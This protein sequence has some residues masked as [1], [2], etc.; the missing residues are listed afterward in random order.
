MHMQLIDVIL[1]NIWIQS[2]L[3]LA[4]IQMQWRC[5]HLIRYAYAIDWC[6]F[7]EHMD[8]KRRNQSIPSHH[9]GN[10]KR[11]ICLTIIRIFVTR[12]FLCQLS[13]YL[14]S[15][16]PD[17]WQCVSI[18]FLFII[19]RMMIIFWKHFASNIIKWYFFSSRIAWLYL[20]EVGAFFN[21]F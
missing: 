5:I 14:V 8:T 16:M 17:G 19:D 20:V 6:N 3:S 13:V 10:K 4:A 21:L 2:G 15:V 12:N 7:D 1:M 18:L 9:K 11:C